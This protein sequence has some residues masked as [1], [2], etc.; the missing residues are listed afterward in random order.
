MP[1]FPHP[2][3]EAHST[4]PEYETLP[5]SIKRTNRSRDWFY[6]RMKSGALPV[7]RDGDGPRPRY[8]L[9]IADVDA[10]LVLMDPAAVEDRS[11]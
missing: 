5:A 8:I 10:L 1:A 7:Y 9:K 2:I 3:A 4:V 6:N 11:R